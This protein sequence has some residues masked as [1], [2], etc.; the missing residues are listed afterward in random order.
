MMTFFATFSA[1][2]LVV[3]ATVDV[4]A[5]GG[6]QSGDSTVRPVSRET[7]VMVTNTLRAV[8]LVERYRPTSLRCVPLTTRLTRIICAFLAGHYRAFSLGS[9]NS[10]G[11]PHVGSGV[12]RIDPLRFLAGRRTRRL[13]QALSVLDSFECVLLLTV[14]ALKGNTLKKINSCNNGANVINSTPKNVQVYILKKIK[15]NILLNILYCG[16][17]AFCVVI[18]CYLCVLSLGCSC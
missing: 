2:C 16:V 15:L 12:V 11:V 10:L 13:N 18:L 6:S 8:C 5:L 7:V 9:F 14:K 1:I 17:N 4:Y 3:N